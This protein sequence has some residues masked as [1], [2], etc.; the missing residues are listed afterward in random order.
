MTKITD[1]VIAQQ[2]ELGL[3]IIDSVNPATGRGS[4]S[5]ETVE[6]VGIRYP[7]AHIMNLDDYIVEHDN[8]HRRGP[9]EITEKAFMYALEV[10]PPVSWIRRD[11]AETFHIS[12]L[13]SGS[14]ANIYCRLEGK[15]FELVDNV[16]LSHSD[17]VAKCEAK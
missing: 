13:L 15:Y 16:R 14:M 11:H 6:E 1:K 7:G 10:L 5:G 8:Q 4:Y 9:T 2:D 12:E 17:I 3:R